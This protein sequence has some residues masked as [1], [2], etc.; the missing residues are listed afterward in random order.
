MSNK[1]TIIDTV[2]TEEFY[3]LWDKKLASLTLS[4]IVE[5]LMDGYE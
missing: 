5:V 2:E 1:I 4:P 3:F